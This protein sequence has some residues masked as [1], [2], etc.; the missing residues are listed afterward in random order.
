MSLYKEELQYCIEERPQCW[1]S[2]CYFCCY[3]DTFL[4][5]PITIYCDVKDEKIILG[6]HK[7]CSCTEYDFT[8]KL[9]EII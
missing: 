3:T 1:F 9:L 7:L 4:L 8:K 5:D 6:E 2:S